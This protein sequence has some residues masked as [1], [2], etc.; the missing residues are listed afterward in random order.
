MAANFGKSME[1]VLKWEGWHSD[2]PDDVGGRTVWGITER[3]YPEEFPAL[4]DMGRDESREYVKTIYRRDYW[5]KVR[6][7]DL[8]AKTDIVVMDSA[9][10]M[11]V[12]FANQ[13]ARYDNF[14][15]II[16]RIE[17]YTEIAKA[18]NGKN[19]KF[20]RGWIRRVVDLYYFIQRSNL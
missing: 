20:L 16:K 19:I 3:D 5:D 10:N 17:R 18:N 2:D 15:A 4:W 11:G 9:V 6:G 14:T 12:Y 7:D 8:P 1:F 13:L